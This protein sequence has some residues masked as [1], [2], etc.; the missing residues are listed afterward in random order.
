M[1][2]PI[3]KISLLF[4]FITT[5]QI[6]AMADILNATR[7]LVA[8]VI[9]VSALPATSVWVKR[10]TPYW[11][12]EKFAAEKELNKLQESRFYYNPQSSKGSLATDDQA[13]EISPSDAQAGAIQGQAVEEPTLE[14]RQKAFTTQLTAAQKKFHAIKPVERDPFQNSCT[15]ASGAIFMGLGLYALLNPPTLNYR[16]APTINCIAAVSAVA[17]A[18]AHA[19]A[20]KHLAPSRALLN[21]SI[22][23]AGVGLTGLA[24]RNVMS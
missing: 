3:L 11:S 15:F 18:G 8:P 20:K 5:Q 21:A 19:F 10:K 13:E 6:N 4:L 24:I 1:K 7:S 14:Q 9:A 17:F 12:K 16:P 22:L 23:T 2:S